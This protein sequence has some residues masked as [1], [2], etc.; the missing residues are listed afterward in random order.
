M[1]LG[2]A[3]DECFHSSCQWGLKW[4][5]KIY[6]N[7]II[8]RNLLLVLSI[9]LKSNKVNI[10]K[11][12]QG[13]FWISPIDGAIVLYSSPAGLVLEFEIWRLISFIDD[14]FGPQ[15]RLLEAKHHTATAHFGTLTQCSV[16]PKVPKCAV[17][18]W[19][20]ASL[21]ASME[22]NNKYAYVITQDI[23]NKI[24]EVI[25]LWEVWFLGQIVYLK[26]EHPPI[27]NKI[28]HIFIY[29]PPFS[30]FLSYSF[31]IDYW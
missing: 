6:N 23:C 18:V 24:I 25:F 17:A 26:I 20:V 21:T 28:S 30:W 5:L 31:F 14:H 8:I 19:C 1:P 13:K 11:G 3:K 10:N 4:H 7:K 22:V 16:H 29:F 27:I 12:K 2:G 15:W 9:N